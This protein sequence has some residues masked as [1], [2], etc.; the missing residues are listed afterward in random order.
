MVAFYL[1][2]N[3]ATCPYFSV[4]PKMKVTMMA[5]K[6][7]GGHF[8][9]LSQEKQTWKVCGLLQFSWPLADLC[10]YLSPRH[11]GPKVR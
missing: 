4:A 10:W 7:F 9:R 1:R 11:Y 2:S 5:L 3:R 6:G 8:Q